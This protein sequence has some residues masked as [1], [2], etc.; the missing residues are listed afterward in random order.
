M[1]KHTKQEI[2]DVSL[3]LFSIKGFDGVSI[4]EIADEVG[5]KDSSIYKHFTSKQMIY[6]T[7]LYDMNQQFENVVKVYPVL[8]G[9]ANPTIINQY[10]KDDYKL[11]RQVNLSIFKYLLI[12]DKAVQFRKMLLMEQMRN[13]QDTNKSFKT[14]FIFDPLTFITEVF[15]SFI[16]KGYFKKESPSLLALNF[17]GPM[18]LLLMQYDNANNNRLEAITKL[19]K[20]MDLFFKTNQLKEQ[21]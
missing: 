13:T 7:I 1:K 16:G 8:Q 6:N 9:N 17:Y 21:I 10:L 14:W 2:I 5:I 11:L 20:H 18:L 12:D 4:K 15:T 19:E 3:R